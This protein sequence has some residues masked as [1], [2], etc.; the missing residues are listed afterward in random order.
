MKRFKS[1]HGV[2]LLEIMLVLAIAA[3]IIVMSVRYY[4]S[5]QASQ[6]ANTV[7]SKLQAILASADALGQAGTYTVVNTASI[8]PLLANA[9]GLSTPWSA[10]ADSI[11][12]AGASASYTVTV[13]NVPPSICG[14]I[15]GKVNG[16]GD[17]HYSAA[18]NQCQSTTAAGNNLVYSYTPMINQ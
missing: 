13:Q 16:K 4:Q 8:K 6:Q 14:L 12:I 2:T 15:Y 9:G 18:D 11:T 5:A 17:L 10:G 3:M 7:L 1:V